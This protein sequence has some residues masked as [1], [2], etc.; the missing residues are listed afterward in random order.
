M[1]SFFLTT[2]I[3]FVNSRPH[4]GTAYEKITADVIAR[5]HRLKG[6]DTWFL[7]GN[8]EHSQNVFRR[9]QEQGKDPLAYCDEMEQVFRDVWRGLDISFDDFIRTTD[10]KRHVPAVQRLVQACLDNGDVYEGTYEGPYC[11]GCEEFKPEKDLVDGLCPIHKTKPEW[12]REKNWFFRLSRYQQPLLKFYADHPSFI[13]PEVRRNEVVRLV[14]DGLVDLSISRAGQ[15]WGIPLPFDPTSVVY[16]WFDALTNY[17]SAVGYG[18]DDALFAKRW[19]ANLHIVGKDITRFHCVIWP[20]MLMSAGLPLPG[21]IFGHGW[22]FFKGE[23][24]SKTM[25]NIVDPL[26]AA[27]RFGPDPLRLYLTK[28]V[29]YGG[30]G[31]FTWERFEEK[32]NADLANNLGNLV[33]RVAAMTERFQHGRLAAGAGGPLAALA[34]EAARSYAGA[35]DRLALHEGVAAAYRLVS[36]ANEYIAETQPWSLAK[37]PAK[38]DALARVLYEAA[39]AVRIAA[40]LLLPVMPSSAA[41]IL[42]RMGE[43]ASPGDLRFDTAT[44]WRTSGE[45]GILNAGALWPRL[46]DKG[47]IT[48]S[49][50]KSGDAGAEAPALHNEAPALHAPAAPAL[51][52]PAAPAASVAPAAPEQISIDEFM[53]VQLKVARVLEAARV[54][55]SKKL[56]QLSVDVGEATP[57]TIL[58][59]I[60]ESYEPEQLVGRTI[61][62][63]A[64]LKPAKLM[65]IESNG[66]VLAASPEGGGALLVNAEPGAPGTRVR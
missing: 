10:Q 37:D 19:P 29:P 17:A 33:N 7:M 59:G 56:V 65:G 63:V 50:T 22:V 53:K 1:T 40:V 20:A 4:L 6:D 66:M 11:V 55:K 31:D 15:S 14:E 64:N 51:H 21:R 28:E 25:G 34:A 38:A 24:M 47:A 52:T 26:D 48:V 58:A 2:A 23:R 18:W 9:A 5:Y 42:R 12:I 27:K 8:D 45:R 44:A 13:E 54:P 49:E 62:V 16:V 39:E 32:Y 41:E 61:V 3:D 30:D 36:A 46:E 60:A 43:P 35:M 57:R